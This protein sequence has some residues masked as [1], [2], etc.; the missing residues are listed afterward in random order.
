MAYFKI[1]V[2]AKRRDNTYPIYIR[3]THHGEVGYLKTDKLCKAKS[4]KKGEVID[5]Y[6]IKELS[7]LIDSYIDRLN[8][9]NIKNWSVKKVIE[10]LNSNSSNP[11]FSSF[12]RL[13]I[14][15]MNNENRETTSINYELALKRLEEFMGKND[16]LFSDITSSIIRGYIESMKDS[17][18]KKHGY[19]NRIKTMFKAGCEKYNDY[20]TGDM[21]IRN[22]PFRGVKIPRPVSP[23]KRAL[24]IEVIKKFIN[25][26]LSNV[27]T[28]VNGLEEKSIRAKNVCLMVFCLAGMNTIDLYYLLPENFKDGKICY[29]RKKTSSRRDDK[30]YMEITV[31]D[32]IK[33]LMEKYKGKRK[34]FNFCETY[35]DSRCF[36][37][38][39]NDGIKEIT[40]LIHS[41]HITVYSFR[42]SWATLAQN[43]FGASLDMVGFCLNHASSHRVTA[44]YVKTDFSPIDRMNEKILNYVFNKQ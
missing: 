23:R 34:L 18:Y 41:E 11:S 22:N 37:K 31:P 26:D 21:I 30:A 2:R 35:C 25:V 40:N 33:P 7:E 6:I 32:I 13:F 9:E 38:A 44:G 1:C 19:P 20:D 42:H 8:R 4:I 27:P 43:V 28:I 17:L 5:N 10:F 14:A 12:C 39:I 16:I 29:C 15:K 3:V 24:D 36:N